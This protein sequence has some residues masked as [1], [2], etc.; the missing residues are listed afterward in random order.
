MS[1]APAQRSASPSPRSAP[2]RAAGAIVA[3]LL[4]LVML[5]GAL[6][7][8]AAAN[9]SHGSEDG[10]IVFYEGNGATQSV[11]CTSYAPGPGDFTYWW[12]FSM[13]PSKWVR[14]NFDGQVCENDEIRSLKL[15]NVP[16]GT[17][18]QVF[19][20]SE[21]AKSDDWAEIVVTEDSTTRPRYRY[22]QTWDTEIIVDTFEDGRYGWKERDGYKIR[23]RAHVGMLG[24]PNLDGKVSCIHVIGPVDLVTVKQPGLTLTQPS[25]HPYPQVGGSLPSLK[26]QPIG[27]LA[28]S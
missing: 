26:V 3:S 16:A 1:T 24:G 10:R 27:Q 17:R 7:S 2:S 9:H 14:T 11:V 5:A 25:G 18:I 15:H 23:W 21:C 28:G 12:F 13:W 22:G 19:D 8:P 20:N 4:S 6:A